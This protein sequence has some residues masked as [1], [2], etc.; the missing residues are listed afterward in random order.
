MLGLKLKTCDDD[1]IIRILIVFDGDYSVVYFIW[2][3]RAMKPASTSTRSV[4]NTMRITAFSV[5][6]GSVGEIK[7]LMRGGMFL[8]GEAVT[9]QRDCR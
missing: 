5:V 1:N 4:K 2:S 3:L 9:G 6:A 8:P 7:R